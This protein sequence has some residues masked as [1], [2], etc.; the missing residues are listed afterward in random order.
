[1]MSPPTGTLNFL[2]PSPN[3]APQLSSQLAHPHRNINGRAGAAHAYPRTAEHRGRPRPLPR[4]DSNLR[5]T[6]RKSVDAVYY[7]VYLRLSCARGLTERGRVT[8]PRTTR[9]R[10]T[11][12]VTHPCTRCQPATH[13]HLQKRV[14]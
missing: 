2:T 12:R 1:M 7:V 5:H 6:V 13:Y 8:R 14:S 11:N 9:V 4:Q 10:V 3:G